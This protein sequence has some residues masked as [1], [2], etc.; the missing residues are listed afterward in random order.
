MWIKKVVLGSFIKNSGA[1]GYSDFTTDIIPVIKGSS[2]PIELT[3]GYAYYTYYLYWRVWIDFNHDG[4]FTDAGEQVFAADYMPNAVGGNVSIPSGAITGQTRMRVSMKYFGA[5]TPCEFFS[6]GEVEDYT[7]SITGTAEMPVA[8]FSAS[9]TTIIPG[10]LVAF[11]DL[12]TGNPTSW[13]WSFPGGTPSTSTNQHPAIT[14]NTTGVYDVTLTASNSAGSD[15]E[16][17]VAYITVTVLPPVANFSAS[18]STIY[19]GQSVTFTDLSTNNPTSYAWTFNGGT[20]GV[21]TSQNPVIT[22]N[23]PGTYDVALTATNSSGSDNETKTAFITVQSLPPAPVAEFTASNTTILAGQSITFTD[24]T[25]NDPTAWAWTFSG[26]TP[27]SSTSQNPVIIYNTPGI[28][29]VILTATNPTGSDTETKLAYIT[30]N[31]APPV[32]NFSASN[33]T[34]QVGQ[35]VNFTDLSTGSPTSWAWTFSGGTPSTSI[36]QNPSVTYNAAG[37]YDVSLTASNSGGSDTE[38]KTG[39]IHVLTAPVTYCPSNGIYYSSMW[40]KKVVLGSF[41]KNSGAAGYSDFT[42]DIIDVYQGS[43]YT[44]ELTPGYAYYTYYVYWRIWVDYNQDGDFIDPG[45]EIF[46]ANYMPNAVSG[47]V[48]VPVSASLGQTRMRVSMKYFGAPASCE[49]FSYGEVEDY[50]INVQ[51]NPAMAG[52][53][54]FS[55]FE[56]R[57]FPNPAFDEITLEVEDRLDREKEVRIYSTYGL[58]MDEFSIISSRR[59]IS[60]RGYK[61]GLYIITINTPEIFKQIKFIVQKQ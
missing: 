60:L 46:A 56:V 45:E 54:P 51:I 59:K 43:T 30:V 18:D 47:S 14:Y 29:N 35:S 40:V 50:T 33:T 31:V 27:S 44:L 48:T 61:P 16:V 42:A 36:S 57:V 8:N 32:T 13:S 49:V 39:Y 4:D 26:G 10:S 58:L 3:P 23:T 7:V 2:F 38:T 22:Y 21:S 6:Y 20:P 53:P 11:T 37:T 52:G 41:V 19:E 5:P 28:Y 34:I 9:P 24:M 17:K 12:T 55:D 25:L 15:T 1:T